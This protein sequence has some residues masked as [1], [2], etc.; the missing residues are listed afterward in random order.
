MGLLQDRVAI[1]TG[2]GGLHGIGRA[3]AHAYARHG[4]RVA[5]AGGSAVD[6]V[7]DEIRADGGTA[8]PIPCDVSSPGDVERL[9]QRTEAELG[10]IDIL[11]N[12]AGILRR[13]HLHEITLDDWNRTLAVNLTGLFLCT[14]VVAARMTARGAGGRIVN[15]SS[16]CGHQGCPGQVSYAASK[17]GV[18]G[19]TKSIA[20]DLGM[21]GI[22]ANCIAP[23]AVYTNMTG[24]PA[25]AGA[26]PVR[27]NGAPLPDFGLPPDV[28]GAAVF[29]A[30]DLASWITAATLIVD[31]GRLVQ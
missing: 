25:P 27:W 18:E 11:C 17:A 16:L 6:Q 19:F 31:G 26:T 9:V 1:V 5:V 22:T 29:L 7:A 15:I 30:S 10:P 28:A 14:Q 4:S 21:H 2:A 20:E 3:I 13:G 8:V 24:S 12:N 23:G